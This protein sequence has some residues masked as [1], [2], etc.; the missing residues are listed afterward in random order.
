MLP[1]TLREERL[2]AATIL[3]VF[4]VS[5]VGKVAVAASPTVSWSAVPMSASC[6]TA[7]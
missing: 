7:S 1:P 3:Q 2:G 4:E 5:K 6:A